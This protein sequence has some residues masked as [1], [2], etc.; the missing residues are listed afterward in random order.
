MAYHRLVN[1]IYIFIIA[2][3]IQ[4]G[5]AEAGVLV[6]P[7]RHIITLPEKGSKTVEYQV[8]NSGPEDL[9]I[10]IDVKDWTVKHISNVIQRQVKNRKYPSL[11]LLI[12]II[13][14]V[15]LREK[16]DYN[17]YLSYINMNL[18]EHFNE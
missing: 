14:E 10:S 8:Y 16:H 15:V 7:E 1:I 13:Y 17:S 18:E 3:S 6:T 12:V 11:L 5:V 4:M 9:D 2:T